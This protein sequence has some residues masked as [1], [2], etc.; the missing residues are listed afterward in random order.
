MSDTFYLQY[1]SSLL[2]LRDRRLILAHCSGGGDRKLPRY[3]LFFFPLLLSCTQLYGLANINFIDSRKIRQMRKINLTDTRSTKMRKVPNKFRFFLYFFVCLF[4]DKFHESRLRT[5]CNT[6]TRN[7]GSVVGK[8]DSV[9]HCWLW[10][11]VRCLSWQKICLL[12]PA[13]NITG[14]PTPSYFAAK[15]IGDKN[16]SPLSVSLP[17]DPRFAREKN[18]HLFPKWGKSTIIFPKSVSVAT[19][20][21]NN[22]KFCPFHSFHLN[23]RRNNHCWQCWFVHQ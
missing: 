22:S 11:R 21:C 3:F 10:G 4:L 18:G 12:I 6:G 9:R 8:E 14:Y 15:G 1:S 7:S 2:G 5:R 23:G 20:L 17:F 13:P 16:G 19:P